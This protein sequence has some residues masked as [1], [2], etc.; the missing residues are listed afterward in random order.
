MAEDDG[1]AGEQRPVEVVQVGVADAAVPY[2]DQRLARTGRVELHL[3]DGQLGADLGH[4]RGA[5]A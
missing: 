1:R 5:H 2:V 4:D 3:V